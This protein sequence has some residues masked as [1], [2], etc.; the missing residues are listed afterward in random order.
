MNVLRIIVGP[1]FAVFLGTPSSRML[2]SVIG[3][4]GGCL[5]FMMVTF[6]TMA[7]RRI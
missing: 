5:N 3:G 4:A 1:P 6:R 2:P 7:G